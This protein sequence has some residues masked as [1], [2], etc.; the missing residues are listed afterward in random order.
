[1]AYV[2]KVYVNGTTPALSA[3]NLNSSE[4]GIYDAHAAIGDGEVSVTINNYIRVGYAKADGTFNLTNNGLRHIFK[5]AAGIRKLE[6]IAPYWSSPDVVFYSEDLSVISTYGSNLTSTTKWNTCDVPDG[7]FFYAINCAN[8]YVTYFQVKEIYYSVLNSLNNKTDKLKTVDIDVASQLK[9]GDAKADGTFG[10]RTDCR[11]I[12]RDCSNVKSIKVTSRCDM[13]PKII[14]YNSSGNVVSY[15]DYSTSLLTQWF[16]VPSSAVKYAANSVATSTYLEQFAISEVLNLENQIQINSN[17][18]L[19]LQPEYADL[20][21]P[22]FYPAVVGF[23][24]YLYFENIISNGYLKQYIVN[25]H[26]K[27]LGQNDK[28]Y[29]SI[30]E[31]SGDETI[32]LDL[33][34]NNKLIKSKSVVQK[35]I[36]ADASGSAT[37]LIIGDSKTAA[38]APWNT[39]NEL[40]SEDS[41]MS[42]TFVGTVTSGDIAREGYSGKS[43]ENFCDDEYIVGTTPNIFYDENVTTTH[44][45]HFSFSKAVSTLGTTPDIVII[46]LGANQ[47]GH[48]WDTVKGCYDDVI[49]SIRSVS[50]AIKIVVV[51][52]EGTGL[53]DRPTHRTNGKWWLDNPQYFNAIK[54]LNEYKNREDENIFILPSYI[55]FDLYNDYPKCLLPTVEGATGEIE[56]CVDGTHP[57][58]GG[59]NYNSGT[60]YTYGTYCIKNGVAYGCKKT[61]TNVNP[62][63]DDGTYWS[64]CNNGNDGYFKKGYIYYYMLKYLMTV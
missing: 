37:V 8:N 43:I 54:I 36:P 20:I 12:F 30:P 39:L 18:I 33:Y 9:T 6:F 52:Q 50:E 11:Y 5:P 3:D 59:N 62:E 34:E 55:G 23:P 1:M 19:N 60:T 53:L 2:K 24:S 42:L 61:N 10:S 14:F 31:E 47:T 46:D 28:M 45:H 64:K 26:G 16:T 13:A 41:D 48:S 32:T 57:G 63:T 25:V 49:D 27:Q 40:L 15:V 29:S 22:E 7:T 38:Q 35:N 56:M 21:L 44:E 4:Q 51:V 58:L 17:A